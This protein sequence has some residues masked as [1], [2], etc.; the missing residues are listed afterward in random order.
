VKKND[1]R[2][3]RAAYKAKQSRIKK[4]KCQ[5]NLDSTFEISESLINLFETLKIIG[6]EEAVFSTIERYLNS[7][8]TGPIHDIEAST[9]IVYILFID[10]LVD[11]PSKIQITT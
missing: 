2:K 3:K 5:E 1:K 8:A 7:K 6:N 11:Q 9:Q 10:W 4:Q